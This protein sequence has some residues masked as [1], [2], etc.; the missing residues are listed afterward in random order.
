MV[1]GRNHQGIW[2][3][4][5]RAMIARQSSGG[6]RWSTGCQ[7]GNRY[8]VRLGNPATILPGNLKR[9]RKLPAASAVA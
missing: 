3:N 9:P 6:I 2:Q 4:F 7:L 1:V 5:K 8:F